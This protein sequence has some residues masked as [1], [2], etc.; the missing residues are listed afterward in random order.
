ML[1]ITLLGDVTIRARAGEPGVRHAL[2]S[3]QAGL[4]LAMLTLE[5]ERGVTRDALADALW[6]AGMPQTWEAS[7][8]TLVSRVRSF[9]AVA[10]PLPDVLVAQAGRYV[11]QLPSDACVDV[12]VA[13]AG[14]TGGEEA[15]AAG[16]ALQARRLASDAVARL[17][18]PFLPRHDGDWVAERRGR[19]GDLLGTGL[20]VVSRSASALGDATGA[21]AA[22]NEAVARAPV[23]ESSHRCLM[24]AHVAAGNRGEALRAYE[25]LRRLLADELGVDPAP[26]TEAAYRQLLGPPVR[27]VAPGRS[28]WGGEGRRPVTFLLVESSTASAR[29]G[30]GE[31]VESRHGRVLASTKRRLDVAFLSAAEAA[32]CAV[33]AQRHVTAQEGSSPAGFGARIGIHTAEAELRDSDIVDAAGDL[34]ARLRSAAHDGQILVSAAARELAADALPDGARLVD[35]GHW[36]LDGDAEPTHVYQLTHPDLAGEFPPLRSS[37][38]G[39]DGIPRQ[40]TSFVGREAACGAVSAAL[41]SHRLVTLTGEGG[42]GKTRLAFEVVSRMH[43]ADRRDG[44][45][46]FDVSDIPDASVL[47]ETM[48]SSLGLAVTAATDLRRRLIARLQVGRPLLLIDSCERLRGP[49]AQLA[50]GILSSG[51]DARL[52]VTGRAQLG[53]PGE[54][55]VQVQPLELPAPGSR[56]SSDAPAVR[57]LVDRAR[58]AGAQVSVDDP[59]LGDVARRLDGLPLALELAARRLRSMPPRSLAARLDRRF[60]LLTGPTR[61]PHRQRT[62]SATIDW[63]FNLLETDAQLLLAALSVFRA[64]WTLDRAETVTTAVGLDEEAVAPLMADLVEQSMIRVET[65]DEGTPRYRML[66]SIHA[67]ARD[68]LA[69]TGREAA[70]GD[71][72]AE[73]FLALAEESARHRRG[74]LERAWVR[75]VDDEYENLRAAFH[76]YVSSGRASGALRLVAALEDDATMRERLEIGRWAADLAASVPAG[77]PL[78]PVALSVASNT[79]M[80]EARLDDALR[81]SREALDLADRAAAPPY[82]LAVNTLAILT[83]AGANPAEAEDEWEALLSLVRQLGRASGN[84]LAEVVAHYERALMWTLAGN[85]EPAVGDAEAALAIGT[86][87]RNPT[88]LAMGLLAHGV[89]LGGRDAER[90]RRAYLE[91]LHLATTARATLLAEQAHRAIAALDARSGRRTDA[92]ASLEAVARRFGESG[93]LNEQLQTVVTMLES[94]VAVEAFGPAATVCGALAATP[95]CRTAACRTADRL[96]AERLPPEVY[97]AARRAGALMLPAELGAFLSQVIADLKAAVEAPRGA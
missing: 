16:D 63:S 56:S 66:E 92:L 25:R 4:A 33:D 82:W 5:R 46:F 23:R 44:V 50:E 72:H 3:P 10:A 8:R 35:I 6:P 89:V 53:V 60:R 84:P 22:A 1:D 17:R 52:L 79:A 81:L 64:G 94:L 47:I 12:E 39:T 2:Q 37:R 83:A 43:P 96:A 69:E 54:H 70:V 75:A 61:S 20:E 42:V 11:L 95:W 85:S 34:A 88:I 86:E 9:V 45:W 30:L 48:A 68:R 24:A 21:L 73:C 40:A 57:L 65:P 13:E 31:I 78:L 27:A 59:A 74:P 14:V 49:V 97:L 90:A 28:G 19:L 38:P 51:C 80:L 76:W 32:A 18:A 91:A 15:I 62:L 55:V 71:R 93:N 77:E 41:R 87:L 58:D 67:Y 36:L 7:L 29:V 26:Q